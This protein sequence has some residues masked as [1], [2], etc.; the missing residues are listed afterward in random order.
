[1][2]Y[3]T[4]MA[5]QAF[6]TSATGERWFCPHGLWSRPYVIPD[7]ATE[8]RLYKK[9]LW[10]MRVIWSGMLFC[11]FLSNVLRSVFGFSR[12][13]WWLA[14]LEAFVAL[15]WL[16]GWKLLIAPE[17]RGLRRSE[18]RLTPPV[19][20]RFVAKERGWT[21]MIVI[22]VLALLFLTGTIV[23]LIMGISLVFGALSIVLTGFLALASGYTLYLK[24]G[25]GRKE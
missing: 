14:G 6:K 22:F 4:R 11:M 24:S 19:L 2:G 3:F 13:L 9:H 1:M 7:A 17:L 21:M 12:G 16:L 18:T 15:W 23:G 8:Q 10:I 25:R 20:Y 5:D